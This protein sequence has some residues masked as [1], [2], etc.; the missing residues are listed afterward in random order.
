MAIESPMTR[1]TAPKLRLTDP[2]QQV[3]IL[4][5]GCQGNHEFRELRVNAVMLSTAKHPRSSP[6]DAKR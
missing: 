3:I 5:L 1:I 4:V 2:S 6:P